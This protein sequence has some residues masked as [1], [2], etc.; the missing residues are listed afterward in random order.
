MIPAVANVEIAS[1]IDRQANRRVEARGACRAISAPAVSSRAGE[2]AHDAGGSDFSD[3]V[4]PRVG[5]V[6]IIR[7]I[8][9]EPGR[10]SE[11]RLLPRAIRASRSAGDT[12]E[13]RE[14]IRF[15]NRLAPDDG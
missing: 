10:R 9:R 15:I 3:R 5:D 2:R 4:V 7:A 11:T 14:G 6:K 13:S 8:D 1:A 12:G